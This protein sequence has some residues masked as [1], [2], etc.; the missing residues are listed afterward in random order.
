MHPLFRSLVVCLIASFAAHAGLV[1]QEQNSTSALAYAADAKTNDLINAGQPTLSSAAVTA[2]YAGFP[3]S[4]INDGGYSNTGTANTYFQTDVHF[5]A[6]ATFQLNLATAP[7]GYDIS[8]ITSL[9]GWAT[10]S[11]YQANQNYTVE[12][13]VVGS[14]GFRPLAHVIYTPF[15]GSGGNYETKV[16][17]TDDTSAPIARNVDA[18]RFIFADPGNN[19]TVV[20]EIDVLGSASAT[21]PPAVTVQT[22]S[23]FSETDN[24]YAGAN[25]V[26]N[27]DLVNKNQPTL[28]SFT[29][30][31]AP[32]FGAGGQ[33]DGLS[34]L[35]NNAVAAWYKPAQLPATLTFNLNTSAYPEGFVVTAIRT[36]AGWKGGG[37]QS[38]ANQKYTVEYQ[39]AGSSTWLPLE[40]VD[41]SPF[42]TLSSTPASTRMVLSAP[43]GNLLSGVAALRFNL[44]VPTRAAG[45]NN[46]TVLQEIDV[47]GYPVNSTPVPT[48]T[49]AS[50]SGRVIV[51]RNGS[52]VGAIP[53]TGNYTATP[54]RIEARAV[55]MSGSNS[56]TT[57][58][59]QTIATA[60]VGGS[61]AG[62]LTNVP[63]GG[64]YRLEVRSAT[65]ATPSATAGVDQI[66]VGDIFITAGQSNS[67]NHGGPTMTPMDSRVVAMSALSGGAWVP[68]ADPQPIATGTGGSVWS[69][70]GDLYTASQ[71]VP[72]GFVSVGVGGTSTSQWLPSTNQ[73]YPR[74]RSAVQ[75]LPV[76]GFKAV[77]WHQGES[78]SIANITAA[79]HQANMQTII[80]QS[81]ADAGWAV[82]WCVAEASFHPNTN[83]T[84]ELLI[85]AG[86]RATAYADPFVQLGPRTDDLHLEGKLWDTV[87][88]NGAGLTDHAQQ[89]LELLIG[90]QSLQV[91]NGTF[92]VNTALADGGV[93]T[94]NTAAT[95]SPSVIGWQMLA[96]GGSAA[97]DG[98]N[99][100]YNP[101]ASSYTNAIDTV[102]GG[103]AP[104][105]SGKHVAFL[106][107]GSAGNHFLQTFRV[108]L[109]P[110]TD[111][112]LTVALGRRLAGVFGGAKIE[113]LADGQPLGTGR[114]VQESDLAL[115]GFTDV[116][117]T[118]RTND[119]TAPGAQ[120]AIRITKLAGT[121][122]Y[123]DFDNV[124]FTATLTGYGQWQMDHFG[125][126]TT[127][128]AAWNADPDEDTLANGIEYHLGNDPVVANIP[129]MPSEVEHDGHRWVRYSAPLAPSVDHSNL[130]LWYAFD[131]STWQPAATNLEG[132]V[133]EFRS[134]TEWALEIDSDIHPNAFFQLRAG[135]ASL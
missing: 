6:T 65:G 17:I 44:Q 32:Q 86:Q 95:S 67:A 10:V 23:D 37:T 60:P 80:S 115:N 109:L 133:V 19:G 134:A 105:M 52:N 92:E 82:P 49:I 29:T 26:M 124:R 74:L 28:A 7:N 103:V 57:T 5:P 127:A 20:R 94:T 58:D 75:L 43:T 79:V 30:S 81:R 12:V 101:D 3:G 130:G 45:T 88:F 62:S 70:L 50:P 13:S 36:I 120:L 87:H 63:A 42:N 89:W 11:Q 77:L 8:T 98:S 132:T 111:Y 90:S 22:V 113:I 91:K 39:N 40:T 135:P 84:Q 34:N 107:S 21:A 121:G 56:G 117:Y 119:T 41:F 125:S 64:W 68:A 31:T 83:L 66:G 4:G 131:L 71:N 59:W 47:V 16:V 116:A 129:P 118:Y 123:L 97:A 72:V 24:A 15:T 100:Y 128:A 48:V 96:A 51:Q 126:T 112:T 114:T 54:D 93:A 2:S 61:F 33:N 46:G 35:A 53:V 14:T 104:N 78:D 69:R 122:T 27:N 110:N 85:N 38:Y 18:I 55:V 99:G 73:H 1:I 108:G 102:N 25:D 76:N 106:F 9:M